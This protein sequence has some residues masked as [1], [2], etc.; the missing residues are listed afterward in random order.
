MHT[1][2]LWTFVALQNYFVGPVTKGPT[3]LLYKKNVY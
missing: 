1:V 3:V 2:S